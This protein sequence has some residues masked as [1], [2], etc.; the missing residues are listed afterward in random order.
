MSD[1]NIDFIET[2][3]SLTKQVFEP[4]CFYNRQAKN[5]TYYSLFSNTALV[6]LKSLDEGKCI[7]SNYKD[8]LMKNG[9]DPIRSGFW[10]RK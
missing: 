10:D 4:T 2:A 9:I 6:R 3:F 7:L 1:K 8:Q 5:A